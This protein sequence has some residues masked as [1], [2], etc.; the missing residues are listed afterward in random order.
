MAADFLTLE[1]SKNVRKNLI[2][3]AEHR[4]SGTI[5]ELARATGYSHGAFTSIKNGSGTYSHGLITKKFLAAFANVCK[6]SETALISSDNAF[7]VAPP[8]EEK[9]NEEEEKKETI[10]MY[11]GVQYSEKPPESTDV[12][13]AE[14]INKKELVTKFLYLFVQNHGSNSWDISKYSIPLTD[15]LK[16][17]D[18]LT[19]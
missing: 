13:S 1:Q 15:V 7:L 14:W 10:T 11:K 18:G 5:N 17:I 6:R 19:A 16:I 3:Y 4:W 2:Y 9:H 8:V 12:K